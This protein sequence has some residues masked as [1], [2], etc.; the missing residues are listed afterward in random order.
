MK[1]TTWRMIAAIIGF[2]CIIGPISTHSQEDITVVEDSAFEHRERPLAI[3]FHD[4]HNEK[5]AIENCAACHHL[6]ENGKL[7]PGESSEGQECSECHGLTDRGNAMPLMKAY[8]GLCK[9]C[10]REK[11]AGPVTCGECHPKD[12]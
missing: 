11:K 5:A 7:L 6:Y 4:N 3:F 1:N 10:H 8:H 2:I 9:S 12:R